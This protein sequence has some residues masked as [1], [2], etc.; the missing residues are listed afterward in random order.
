MYK[1]TTE[2]P[3][4]W[5]TP[6][7]LQIGLDNP[8]AVLPKLYPAEERM[9]SALRAGFADASLPAI[10]QECGLTNSESAALLSALGPALVP[11]PPRPSWRI[12]LDGSG[13]LVDSLGL[14]LIASGHR[15]VKA[16]ASVASNS[17]LAIVI[18]D[19]A[20]EPHRPG[21][22]LSQEVPHLPVVFSDESVR[23][24]PLLGGRTDSSLNVEKIPCEQCIELT[25]RDSDESWV[26]MIS[27]L[28]RTPAPSH[29]PLLD[30]E[31]NAVIA[32]LIHNP[33]THQITSNTALRIS[34]VDGARELVTYALH[35]DCAC[36]ALP[37]NV[38]VLGSLHG[39]SPAVPTIKKVAS[40]HA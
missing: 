33:T 29:H 8:R 3:L 36:Q 17:N 32:R 7:S 13:P 10:S 16:S 1:L 27:Q 28:T 5:R 31:V 19:F 12:A 35:P 21:G 9:I 14:L 18:G 39:L 40:S 38:S 22:W 30:A 23:I 26:A 2:V 11:S 37:R 4:I 25:H 6:T 34:A 15:V 20:L 24:G